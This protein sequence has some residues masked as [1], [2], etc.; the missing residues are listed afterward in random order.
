MLQ[1]VACDQQR[2]AARE[3]LTALRKQQR[4]SGHTQSTGTCW[5]NSPA[6]GFVKLPSG[7]AVEHLT[8]RESGQACHHCPCASCT[9]TSGKGQGIHTQH[10]TPASSST[11]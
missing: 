1:I 3:A 7:T 5:L 11:A 9:C 6:D 10:F 8:A 4:A 2:Q